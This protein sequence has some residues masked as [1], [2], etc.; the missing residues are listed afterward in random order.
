MRTTICIPAMLAAGAFALWSISRPAE[1]PFEKT[2]IDGGA[3]ETAAFADINGDGKLDIV[4]GEYWYEA[5]KWTPHRFR[6][7]EFHDGYID[8]FSDL[9]LDVNGDGRVDI[10][11]CTWMAK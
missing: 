2:M 11:S 9:P 3:S 1:V 7:L 4:S 5:S 6:E 10:I 8:D